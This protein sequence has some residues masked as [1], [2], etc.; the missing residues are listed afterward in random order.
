MD[1]FKFSVLLP[2]TAEILVHPLQLSLITC[3]FGTNDLLI[4][5]KKRLRFLQGLASLIHVEENDFDCEI[6]LKRKRKAGFAS[7]NC[8]ERLFCVS[9]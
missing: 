7:Q 1:S 6:D 8:V 4:M 2:E 3:S 9:S 5:M